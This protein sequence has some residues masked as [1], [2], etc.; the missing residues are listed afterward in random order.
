MKYKQQFRDP[1]LSNPDF[2]H[3]LMEKSDETADFQPCCRVCKMKVCCYKA[4]TNENI[5]FMLGPSE[6]DKAR[7]EIKIAS[8]I[9]EKNL[10]ISISEDLMV[11]I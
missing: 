7:M 3:W 4:A 11:L 5:D 8:F 9:A 6:K 10:P 2:K 1:C